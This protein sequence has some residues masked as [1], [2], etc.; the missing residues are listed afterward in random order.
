MKLKKIIRYL[1]KTLFVLFVILFAYF[2]YLAI[3]TYQFVQ[4]RPRENHRKH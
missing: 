2:V 1:L 4:C 3:W